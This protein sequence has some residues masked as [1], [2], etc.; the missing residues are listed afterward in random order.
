MARYSDATSTSWMVKLPVTASLANL[1]PAIS[2]NRLYDLSHL[3]NT[4]P[5]RRYCAL[6]T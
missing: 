2:L 4:Q 1:I 6:E 5:S 3:H